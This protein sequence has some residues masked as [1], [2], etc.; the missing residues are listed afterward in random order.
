AHASA[1]VPIAANLSLVPSETDLAA[2]ESELASG[3][4][5]HRRLAR[6]LHPLLPQFD[7]ILI[8][9]PPSLGML[10]INGLAAAREVIIP[11]QAHFL[12]LKGVGKLLETVRLVQAKLN[13]R[14]RVTGVALCM[15]D[16][17]STHTQEV[18][19]DIETYFEAARTQDLPWRHAQ[20]LRPS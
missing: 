16:A 4:D 15:H 13:P 20:V 3:Q 6:A 12:A 17:Q 7:F 5:R 8:D 2:A 11:M 14:L 1:V 10:T 19:S 9:C 18:V